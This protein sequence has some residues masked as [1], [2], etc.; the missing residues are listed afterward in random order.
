M[1]AMVGGA[2][3]LGLGDRA[4]PRRLGGPGTFASPMRANDRVPLA[5]VSSDPM[6][7]EP[8][9]D[10]ERHQERIPQQ[11]GPT[12]RRTRRVVARAPFAGC[13]LP[14]GTSFAVESTGRPL[15]SAAILP[16]VRGHSEVPKAPPGCPG[17]PRT[18]SRRT[19]DSLEKVLNDEQSSDL[20]CTPP[21][22]VVGHPPQGQA[23]EEAPARPHR[24][25]R[26]SSTQE[27]VGA[28]RTGTL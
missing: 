6:R 19:S 2:R 4:G 24:S 9:G 25:R 3:S 13:G 11:P 7:L 15:R 8:R 16:R 26:R 12:Q 22:R 14:P 5:T 23:P 20:E 27:Q 21:P 17:S 10:R 1:A 18:S 28:C